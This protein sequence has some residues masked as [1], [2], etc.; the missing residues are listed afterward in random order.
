MLQRLT[1][2]RSPG[3]PFNGLGLNEIDSVGGDLNEDGV[4]DE[5]RTGGAGMLRS[6]RK[7]IGGPASYWP[8]VSRLCFVV[9]L[10]V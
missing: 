6:Y 2:T 9:G 8:C 7:V 4:I 10:C 1:A 5:V 3:L